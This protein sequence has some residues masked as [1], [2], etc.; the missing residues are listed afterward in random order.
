MVTNHITELHSNRESDKH[1]DFENE[2]ENLSDESTTRL[3][4]KR[5]NRSLK[6]TTNL[7]TS[8]QIY[9]CKINDWL[10]KLMII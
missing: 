4:V 3:N 5:K 6:L 2:Q 7:D 10:L 8:K 1:S 9:C